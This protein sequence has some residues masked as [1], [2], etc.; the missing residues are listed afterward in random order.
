MGRIQR[1]GQLEGERGRERGEREEREGRK[2]EGERERGEGERGKRERKGYEK[3]IAHG[4]LQRLCNYLFDWKA[5]EMHGAAHRC[6]HHTVSGIRD[7]RVAGVLRT[8]ASERERE[9]EKQRER[10]TETDET[11]SRVSPS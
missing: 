1:E 3:V 5:L 10:E 4:R 2:S 8:G 11:K 7:G 9:R 6:V